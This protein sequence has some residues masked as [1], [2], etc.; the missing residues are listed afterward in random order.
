METLGGRRGSAKGEE[1][2]C[3]SKLSWFKWFIAVY[4]LFFSGHGLELKRLAGARPPQVS[5]T[6]VVPCD[7]FL[8][9]RACVTDEATIS[10]SQF[11]K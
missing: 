7:C 2:R 5:T 11:R 10:G 4:V 6:D 8:L 9:R 1:T 3:V